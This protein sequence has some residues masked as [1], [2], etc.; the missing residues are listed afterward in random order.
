MKIIETANEWPE[1]LKR[2][3]DEQERKEMDEDRCSDFFKLKIEG[4]IGGLEW[5]W[6]NDHSGWAGHLGRPNGG[7]RCSF[8]GQEV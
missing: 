5:T 7:P 4:R 8:C 2:Q 6:C 1:E 3:Y